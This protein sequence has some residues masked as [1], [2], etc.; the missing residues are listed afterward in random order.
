MPLGTAMAVFSSIA[1]VL[2]IVMLMLL[3]ETRGR[4]IANLDGAAVDAANAGAFAFRSR[5]AGN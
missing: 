4:S 3:P 2:M 5:S 1:M